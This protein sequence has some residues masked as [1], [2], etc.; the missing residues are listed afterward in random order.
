VNKGG[1]PVVLVKL[2]PPG[3]TA[4]PGAGSDRFSLVIHG[5][6]IKLVSGSGALKKMPPHTLADGSELIEPIPCDRCGA[7]AYFVL[8][9]RKPDYPEVEIQI[10][11]CPACAYRMEL[12]DSATQ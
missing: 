2:H 6:R 11:Q 12:V 1:T 5:N 9:T 10:F 3:I 7:L 4:A 8:R